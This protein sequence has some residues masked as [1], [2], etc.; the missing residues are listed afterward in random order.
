MFKFFI[1]N[2]FISPNQLDFKP[3]I[4][5][6]SINSYPLLTISMNLLT[7]DFRLRVSPDI[8]KAFDKFWHEEL[9]HTL[10]QRGISGSVEDFLGSVRFPLPNKTLV[11]S[12][13]CFPFITG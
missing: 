2:N 12:I 9:L 1:D 7:M 13:G 8:S 6:V 4:N 3:G 11:S 10:K 5:P